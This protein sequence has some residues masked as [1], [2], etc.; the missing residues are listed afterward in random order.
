L[1]YESHNYGT[2]IAFDFLK[3]IKVHDE[4]F[5]F[6]RNENV[7]DNN[8][9]SSKQFWQYLDIYNNNITTLRMHITI[10]LLTWGIR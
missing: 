6:P 3:A 5:S 9:D 10:A 7:G 2:S 8:D 1:Q 4:I